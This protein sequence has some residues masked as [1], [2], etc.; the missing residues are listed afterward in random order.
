M[1]RVTGEVSFKTPIDF[2]QVKA[3]SECPPPK[4]TDP[5]LADSVLKDVLELLE[6]FE[7]VVRLEVHT[8]AAKGGTP[9]FWDEVGLHRRG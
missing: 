9:A 7:G 6:V 3:A 8:K 5:V 4:F 2:A 1:D